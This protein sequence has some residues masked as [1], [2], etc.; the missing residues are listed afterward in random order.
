VLE[1]M[2]GIFEHNFNMMT[3]ELAGY[4]VSDTLYLKKRGEYLVQSVYPLR[5]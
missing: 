1:D 2:Q 5:R 4:D 3:E